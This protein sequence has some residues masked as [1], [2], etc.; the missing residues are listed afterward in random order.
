MPLFTRKGTL[1]L[2]EI[3]LCGLEAVYGSAAGLTP[4]VGRSSPSQQDRAESGLETCPV[5]S[6]TETQIPVWPSS[7]RR[8]STTT[9]GPALVR[10]TTRNYAASC[11]K[12]GVISGSGKSVEPSHTGPG[13]LHRPRPHIPEADNRPSAPKTR[14]TT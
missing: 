7:R 2:S 12:I 4:P 1:E 11:P 3:R 6:L 5:L 9:A 14:G 10:E 13:H 8:S